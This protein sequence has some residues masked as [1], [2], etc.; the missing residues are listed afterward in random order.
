[1]L[2][3]VDMSLNSPKF[4]GLSSCFPCRLFAEEYIPKSSLHAGCGWLPSH[5]IMFFCFLYSCELDLEVSL[6]SD[7]IFG[8]NSAYVVRR[9]YMVCF[10]QQAHDIWWSFYTLGAM[11]S[12]VIFMITE[13]QSDAM[14]A[15]LFPGRNRSTERNFHYQSLDCI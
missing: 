8:K 9:A 11:E 7:S 12:T 1:M 10:H 14:N 4:I 2:Q 5:V 3:F 15:S 13:W 6:D